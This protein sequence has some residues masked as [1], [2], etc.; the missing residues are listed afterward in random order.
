M[1]AELS[2]CGLNHK[3]AP[4]SLRERLVIPEESLQE[5]LQSLSKET[6]V[7]EAVILSTCH[8]TEIYTKNMHTSKIIQWMSSFHKIPAE[9]IIPHFYSYQHQTSFSHAVRVASGLDSMVLGEPQIFGQLKNAVKISHHVGMLR[10]LKGTFDHVFSVAKKIRT[11]TE[12]GLHPVSLGY[13]I[14]QLARNIF[15]NISHCTVLFIGA[16]EMIT[17]VG[18]YFQQQKLSKFFIANR[19][20]YNAE[21]TAFLF[22][23]KP[24]SLQEIPQAFLEADIV[25]SAIHSMTPLIGKG[26]VETAIKQRKHRPILMIDLAVPRNIENEIKSLE[27]VYLYHLEDLQEIIAKNQEKRKSAVEAAESIIAIETQKFYDHFST[28]KVS[29]LVQAYRARMHVIRDE[30]VKQALREISL[31]DKPEEVLEKMAYQ[32]TN[33]LLHEPSQ[34]IKNKESEWI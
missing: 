1:S 31:G 4:L 12:I 10:N 3:T 16:G 23:A 19:T 7:E 17:L 6:S 33:K 30:I 24:L 2:T 28:R 21:K 14:L 8:R 26:M 11:E 13:A 5:A 15:E 18:K 27:D 32:L 9:K 25:V 34:W 20:L 29:K 22:E